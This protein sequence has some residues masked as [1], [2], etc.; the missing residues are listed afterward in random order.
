VATDLASTYPDGAWFAELAALSEPDLVP[1]AVADATGAREQPGRPIAETVTEHLGEKRG[2]L[3]LDNCEHLVDAAA[4]LVDFLLTSCAHLK[5]LA[6][7]REPLSVEGEILFSVPPLPVPA[8]LLGD[9]AK[10][11]GDDSVQLFVERARLRLPGFLLTKEN[12]RSVVAVCNRLEGLPLAIELAAA[13]MGTLAIDEMAQKL[14]DS[15]DLLSTGP[16][17]VPPRQ[18][19]MR[20]AIGWS[21]ELLSE[22]EKAMFRR[23]SVFAGGFTLEAAEAVCPGSIIEEGEV[24]NLASRLVDKSLV[25]AETNA[26]GRVR[27]LMLEPVRQY[28]HELLVR[29]GEIEEAR[30]G[31]AQFFRALAERAEPEL[32]GTTQEAW[33]GRLEDEHD[34]FRA[35]L[36]WMVEK[37]EVELALRLSAVLVEFWHLH[38]HHTEAQRWLEDALAEEGGSPPVRMKALERACFLAWEQGD[39]ERAVVLGED[40]LVLARRFGD[41]ASAAAILANLGSVAMSRME[42]DRASALLEEAVAMYRASGDEWGL[43]YA[44][45]RLGMVA[46]VRRD[47]VRAM[48]LHEES[49]TLARKSGDEVGIVQALGL[50]ALTALIRGDYR[51]AEAL[52]ITGTELS[53]RLEI[54]HYITGYFDTLGSSAS[55]R[56]RSVR[57]IRLWAAAR[58]LREAMGIPRMPA[59]MAFYEPYVEAAR[60]QLDDATGKMAW[61]EGQAMSMEQAIEYALT[62]ESARTTA[63]PVPEKPPAGTRRFALTRGEREVATLLTQQGLT[64]RQIAFELSISEHTVATHIAKIMKKLGLHSRGQITA[65]VT[66]QRIPSRGSD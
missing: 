19:T 50:G 39:Y 30:R 38:V 7:S 5:V 44:L 41:D 59:E 14:D 61:S 27:Y 13:R 52:G 32:K 11:G 60:G 42:V 47:H 37:G 34:N 25:V 2:L 35:A 36:S 49:L 51:Q 24:L 4:R 22:Q 56:G 53:W 58:S 6:T 65:W 26:E 3:V 66:A 46:V 16:R 48:T 55:V 64:N 40:G 45:Y 31:H 62:E 57:A 28:A 9:P 21:H 18:R 10:I 17:T 33:L 23:L 15:L 29:S 8:G 63:V 12:A 43:S 54:G 20:A 1:Q